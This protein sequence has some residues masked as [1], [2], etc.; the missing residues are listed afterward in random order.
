MNGED[1]TTLIEPNGTA[2]KSLSSRKPPTTILA[3]IAFYAYVVGMGVII[4]T[5]DPLKMFDNWSVRTESQSHNPYGGSD[6]SIRLAIWESLSPG[7]KAL[8][9]VAVAALLI[10]MTLLSKKLVHKGRRI[11]SA[12]LIPCLAGI[13]ILFGLVGVSYLQYMSASCLT[14]AWMHL[15]KLAIAGTVAALPFLAFNRSQPRS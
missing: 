14:D 11:S 6:T 8:V 13:V 3:I 12:C 4:S 5:L 1:K 15:A 9:V 10:G 2:L 7:Q